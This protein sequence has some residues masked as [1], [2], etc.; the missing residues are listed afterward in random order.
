M[1]HDLMA[2]KWAAEDRDRRIICQKP[3]LLQKMMASG[4]TVDGGLVLGDTTVPP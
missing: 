4:D 1:L 3:A 2:L